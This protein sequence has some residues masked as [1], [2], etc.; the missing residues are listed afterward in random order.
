MITSCTIFALRIL[1]TVIHLARV[2]MY[3]VLVAPYPVVGVLDEPDSAKPAHRS[4][5]TGPP[6]YIRWTDTVPAYE[7]WRACTATP[8]S[9]IS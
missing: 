3:T 5:H 9:G 1:C 7:D 6:G 2:A 4:S 8:L